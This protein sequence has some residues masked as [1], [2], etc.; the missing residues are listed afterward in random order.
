VSNKYKHGERVPTSVLV[1]R[2]N[3][4]SNEITKGNLAQF[5]MRVPAELD[6]CPDLVM[7]AAS[8]R[9]LEFEKEIA[10]LKAAQELKVGRLE[11]L[12]AMCC[13]DLYSQTGTF[14][15][16]TALKLCKYVNEN[17]ISV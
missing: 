9:L 11:N 6:H 8:I 10:E 7:S 13:R 15:K 4:L 12:L 17:G 1:N 14:K 3:E 2:L 16:S 5:V